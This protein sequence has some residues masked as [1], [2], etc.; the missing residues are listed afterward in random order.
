[1]AIHTARVMDGS[2]ACELE[3]S[4]LEAAGVVAAGVAVLAAAT[5]LASGAAYVFDL[6]S[7][8]VAPGA[9]P[10]GT[11][12]ALITSRLGIFL[13]SMQLATVVL[14]LAAS[15][16]F[17][18]EPAVFMALPMPAGGAAGIVK[19]V[20]V[21]L[22]L[23]AVYGAVVLFVH[24]RSLLNDVQVFVDMMRTDTWWIVA[25]TAVIGAPLAE[26]ILFR[27]LMY[28]VL[29]ASPVGKIGAAVV[30]SFVWA[31]GHAEYSAYGLLAIFLIGLYLAFVR[32]KTNSL[33]APMLCHGAYNLSIVLVVLL[34]PDSALQPG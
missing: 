21:L 20:A 12:E 28:G 22:L 4:W 15:R 33:I 5:L 34:A 3:R 10:P 14:T 8:P 11:L 6:L 23:A 27:G 7:R 25:M 19:S 17:R 9:H 29:R 24:Q 26:E 30:T 31:Y 1:M 16:L 2:K 18:G 13:V 32:E